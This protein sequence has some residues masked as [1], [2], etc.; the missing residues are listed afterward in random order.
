MSSP[1]EQE[2]LRVIATRIDMLSLSLGSAYLGE[3]AAALHDIA[4][5][6]MEARWEAWREG[7]E[8]CT[9]DVEARSAPPGPNGPVDPTQNPY[10]EATPEPVA[11]RPTVEELA[12]ALVLEG[13]AEEGFCTHP[14]AED[15]A[16]WLL[17][18]YE[19]RKA[20]R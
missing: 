7:Y 20:T 11:E 1:A 6:I 18:R 12:E 16:R 2:R 19:I 10:E 4:G 3:D 17:K 15:I 14:A 8:A 13:L 5:K 9:G